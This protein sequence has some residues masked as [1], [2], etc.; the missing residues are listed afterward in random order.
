MGKNTLQMDHVNPTPNGQW[1]VT[2]WKRAC[3]S[4]ILAN[5]PV[6]PVTTVWK[7]S[8]WKGL[9]L[10]NPWREKQAS[11]NDFWLHRRE[12]PVGWVLTIRC[13]CE[14]LMNW[15]ADISWPDHECQQKILRFKFTLWFEDADD[16]LIEENF[17]PSE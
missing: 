12:R 1:D 13:H 6:P 8:Q 17:L 2:N 3:W 4:Q 14:V 5:Y 7:S 15:A 10:F 16:D 9:F 11:D